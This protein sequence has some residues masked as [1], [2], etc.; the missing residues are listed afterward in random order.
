MQWE[1]AVC[2]TVARRRLGRRMWGEG[3]VD[4][5]EGARH[6]RLDEAGCLRGQEIGRVLFRVEGSK[7]TVYVESRPGETTSGWFQEDLPVVP[8]RGYERAKA[9]PSVHVLTKEAIGVA[10]LG[11]GYRHVR[12]S[13]KEWLLSVDLDPVISR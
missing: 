13:V 10:R 5:K 4:E 2:A 8:A 3:R 7:L 6:I 11:K 9:F 12:R 1:V